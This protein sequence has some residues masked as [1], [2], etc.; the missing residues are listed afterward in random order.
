MNIPVDKLH[1][2]TLNVGCCYHDGDWNWKNV[3]SPFSRLYYVTEGRAQI[4][5]PSGTYDLTPR[6]LY[7]I[8]AYTKHNCIC[9][10]LFTH[11]YI[12]IFED[13]QNETAILGDFNMPVEVEAQEDDLRLIKRLCEINPFL[14][15]PASNPDVYDNHH[16]LIENYQKNLLRPFCDKVESRGIIF[17]LLSHFLR[18]AQPK[19]SVKD[20]RIHQAIAFIRANINNR[21]DIDQLAD[22]ACM[23]KGHFF[24]MFKE[25]TGDT[26]TNYIIRRKMEK[27]ELLLV[28][29]DNPVKTIADS[30]GYEDYSYFNR[31]FK[32]STGVTPQQ[33][34]EK[35]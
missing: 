20:D 27:A 5:L 6:H 16:M 35:H 19:A 8:P 2:F 7:F 24:R 26:P 33:Y 22:K 17:I 29:T 18:Y 30:L 1:L 12:H 28:T 13:M 15:I 14:K 21:I 11:Y 25:E 23:S 31:I 3:R 9:N 10:S 34:R 32:K 4:E